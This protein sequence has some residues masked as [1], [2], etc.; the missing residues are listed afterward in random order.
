MTRCAWVNL[1]NPLYVKYHDEEWGVPTY[2]DQKLFELLILEINQAGL[3][4][5]TILKKR[6]NFQKSY[7]YFEVAKVK[8]YNETKIK[9]LMQDEGIIRNRQKI[10]AAIINAQVFANIAEEFGSFSNYIWS[11]TKRQ[12][13]KGKQE[14]QNALSTKISKDLKAR[15]MVFV[16]STIIY[17]YLQAIGIINDHDKNCFK[18]LG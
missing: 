18:A 3:S 7:D 11:F 12:V 13:I 15:G 16:G 4:W 1:A 14:T 6:A 5:E 2:D 10:Q 17:A 9:A 8:Q